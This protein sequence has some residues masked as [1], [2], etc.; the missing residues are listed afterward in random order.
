MTVT[1]CVLHITIVIGNQLKITEFSNL[2]TD[3]QSRLCRSRATAA[4]KAVAG[5]LT[6]QVGFFGCRANP[7]TR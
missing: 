7:D 2:A 1:L 6:A 3:P 5:E 4:T